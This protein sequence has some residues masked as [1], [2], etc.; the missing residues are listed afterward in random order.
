MPAFDLRRSFFYS[1]ASD[2]CFCYGTNISSLRGKHN[3]IFPVKL[4]NQRDAKDRGRLDVIKP[5]IL[6]VHAHCTRARGRLARIYGDE[7]RWCV[8]RF[9]SNLRDEQILV[10]AVGAGRFA[11]ANRG[12]PDFAHCGRC[13][14]ALFFTAMA[15]VGSMHAPTHWS[16]VCSRSLRMQRRTL[17]PCAARIKC[18]W[19]P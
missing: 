2:L 5:H 12:R 16:H 1:A 8:Q 18:H 14:A 9:A 15:R 17:E 4:V 13:R 3:A 6:R 7:D 10:S 19:I 11:I